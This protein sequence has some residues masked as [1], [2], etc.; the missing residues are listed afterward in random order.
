MRR[1]AGIAILIAWVIPVLACNFPMPSRQ[2]Q[3]TLNQAA[4]QT[5]VAQQ[6]G[7][8]LASPP[9][10]PVPP[11]PGPTSTPIPTP[12]PWPFFPAPADTLPPGDPP[13]GEL[14]PGLPAAMMPDSEVIYSP[15]SL[16]FQILEYVQNAGGFLSSYQ[17]QV[18]NQ[19]LSGVEIVQLVALE[20][21]IN[22][23]LLLAI[24]EYQAHWVRGQPDP[25]RVD[26][27]IGFYVP[28]YRGLYKELSLTAK[29]LGTGY[30]GWRQGT[31]SSL[32]FP[33]FTRLPLDPALNAGSVALQYLFS[34]LFNEG[35]WREKLF[36]PE[37]F[38]TLY[39]QMYGDALLRSALVE[40]L[41]PT[42][43]VQPVLELPFLPGERWSFTAG[44]HNAWAT[45]SPR[46]GIDFA[47][48]T[49]EPACAVSRAWVTASA[50]G[51]VVRSSRNTVVIDLDGDGYEQTGWTLVYLHLADHER[52]ALGAWVETDDR[53]GHPSCEGGRATGTNVHMARKY[54]GEWLPA[55]SAQPFVLSGWVVRAGERAYEGYLI[56]GDQVVEARPDGSHTSIIVRAAGFQ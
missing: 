38:S 51:L 47:P 4:I 19:T 44:P 37:S 49:G 55:E 13:P 3:P 53:L 56:N 50:S 7:T 42:G 30:Y 8:A 1:W 24:L 14:P 31:I 11:T 6:M 21:S 48:V 34:T 32:E 17:E 41:F 43:L 16:D 27:P 29:Q 26:Y 15:S 54:N 39:Q 46:G 9:V 22:P 18:D 52:V 33:D 10:Q 45:G 40:P 5:L 12:T 28:G 36:G 23:R 20:T 35:L 2:P 25:S